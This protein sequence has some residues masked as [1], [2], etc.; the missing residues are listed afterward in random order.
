M[1]RMVGNPRGGAAKSG[2]GPE[3][4]LGERIFELNFEE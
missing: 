4:F 3:N 2:L 1:P